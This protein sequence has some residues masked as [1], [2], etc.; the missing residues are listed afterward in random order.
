MCQLGGVLQSIQ[1]TDSLATVAVRLLDKRKRGDVITAERS[2]IQN[3][4]GFWNY[5][6]II[7]W[8]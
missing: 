1:S 2:S 7:C 3:A 6:N 8:N 4:N 5:W